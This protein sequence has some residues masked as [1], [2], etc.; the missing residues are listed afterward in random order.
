MRL[1]VLL[2]LALAFACGGSTPPT[3]TACASCPDRTEDDT[4]RAVR[5]PVAKQVP[6]ELRAHDQVRQ[7]PYYWMRDDD[8][9]DEEILAHLRAEN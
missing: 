3:P 8:R 7:D 1:F 4:P 2:L 6:H 9:D 5:P